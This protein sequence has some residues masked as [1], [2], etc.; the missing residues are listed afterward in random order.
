MA[1]YAFTAISALE[2]CLPESKCSG[3]HLAGAY[4]VT[5]K[6]NGMSKVKITATLDPPYP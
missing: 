5:T 4:E 1:K 2:I 6:D 3:W